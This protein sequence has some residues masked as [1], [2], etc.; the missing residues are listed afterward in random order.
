MDLSMMNIDDRLMYLENRIK[1]LEDE[2]VGTTNAL[3]EIENRLQSQI[4]ALINYT[5]SIKDWEKPN[6]VY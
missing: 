2:N 3:Y 5:M 4:D 1:I 6:D